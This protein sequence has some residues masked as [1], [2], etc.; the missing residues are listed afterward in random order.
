MQMCCDENYFKVF[1]T[2]IALCKI[3]NQQLIYLDESPFI[4]ENFPSKEVDWILIQKATGEKH[5][6]FYQ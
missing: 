4:E 3:E 1:T 5:F 6:S 2:G